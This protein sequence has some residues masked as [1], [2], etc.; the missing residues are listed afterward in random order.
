MAVNHSLSLS[1]SVCTLCTVTTVSDLCGNIPSVNVFSIEPDPLSTAANFE[2]LLGVL[3]VGPGGLPKW[4]ML[5]KRCDALGEGNCS[6]GW[7]SASFFF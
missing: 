7:A 4:E 6:P 1:L 5:C 2:K 3:G